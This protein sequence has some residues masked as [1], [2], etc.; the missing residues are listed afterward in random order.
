MPGSASP[1]RLDDQTPEAREAFCAPEAVIST[2][3]PDAATSPAQQ[4][5]QMSALTLRKP[6]DIA[7]E[8]A[9][10]ATGPGKLNFQDYVQLRLFDDSFIGGADKSLF[11][12]RHTNM[13]L[14]NEINYDRDWHVLSTNKVAMSSYLAAHGFPT[15][16]PQAIYIEGVAWPGPPLLSDT[17]Q[18]AAFLRD[19]ADYPL[20]CKPTDGRQ[21]LGSV[22]LTGLSDDKTALQVKDGRWVSLEDF[23]A[24][25]SKTYPNGYLIQSCVRPA[26]E[27]AEVTQGAL[28][29]VR[30]LTCFDDG[31]ARIV[32]ACLK[33]PSNGNVADNYWR[34]GNMLARL[35][36]DTGA[37]IS[38]TEGIGLGL[39]EVD[40]DRAHGGLLRPLTVP[41]WAQLKDLAQAAQSLMRSLPILGWDIA[42]SEAG[43]VIVEMNVTPDAVLNQIADRQGLLEPA[44]LALAAR[45]RAAYKQASQEAKAALKRFTVH[46]A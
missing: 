33:L 28:A 13:K 14:V 3:H 4:L 5:L 17:A 19:R 43:P 9:R 40:L 30:V 18:L 32:R 22:V 16:A 7:R 11:A 6:T 36:M 23:A 41:G 2:D 21:S 39:S 8:F 38:A 12:G 34:P 31:E 37:L 10:L 15:I 35:D 20:F 45:H 24:F 1:I 25:I 26:R 27:L 42:P 29:T 46:R 44:L